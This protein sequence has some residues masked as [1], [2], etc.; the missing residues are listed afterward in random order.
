MVVATAVMCVAVALQVRHLELK[1]L[2][3]FRS[4]PEVAAHDLEAG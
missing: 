3:P 2:T 4:Y 1:L